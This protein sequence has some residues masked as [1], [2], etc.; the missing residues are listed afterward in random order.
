MG[1]TSALRIRLKLQSSVGG[2][3]GFGAIR[4]L[5]PSQSL[6]RVLDS[7]VRR[8]LEP[9]GSPGLPMPNGG[10]RCGASTRAL[11]SHKIERYLRGS[12]RSDSDPSCHRISLE[13]VD[14]ISGTP[15]ARKFQDLL[16]GV[17]P[18]AM[19]SCGW[20]EADHKPLTEG[21]LFTKFW[22]VFSSEYFCLHGNPDYLPRSGDHGDRR[23]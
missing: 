17:Q 1:Q 8:Q 10:E 12:S 9:F 5:A 3:S 4:A 6:S 22:S 21:I 11:R 14:G 23:G 16:Q 13:P 19:G 20:S 18:R 2:I 7:S 15:V